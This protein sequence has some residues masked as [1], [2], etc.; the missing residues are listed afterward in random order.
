[1]T[2]DETRIALLSSVAMAAWL[3]PSSSSTTCVNRYG[4][5]GWKHTR[6]SHGEDHSLGIHGAHP[7]AYGSCR[8][9]CGGWT[10]RALPLLA[11][12]TAPLALPPLRQVGT[13]VVEIELG[14]CGTARLCLWFAVT[15]GPGSPLMKINTRR[16]RGQSDPAMT[17]GEF[18][19]IVPRY[20]LMTVDDRCRTSLVASRGARGAARSQP[21]EVRILDGQRAGRFGPRASAR[22]AP[23]VV[24][25]DFPRRCW[26]RPSARNHGA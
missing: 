10:I 13:L 19:R 20:D 1:M 7:V 4:S 21:A 14:A 15:L 8:S 5:H 23:R 11:W 26:L 6:R 16:L 12:T 3:P 22:Q 2:H 17:C 25:L 18:D 9:S 24:G